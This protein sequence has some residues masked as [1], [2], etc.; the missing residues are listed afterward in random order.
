M[1]QLL[2]LKVGDTVYLY[3]LVCLADKSEV[4]IHR[5]VNI[6]KVTPRFNLVTGE[7]ASGIKHVIKANEGTVYRN[8]LWLTE[9]D[10]PKAKLILIENY[11]RKIDI[12]KHDI[13]LLQDRI[14]L[15]SES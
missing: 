4:F 2:D 8:L 15:I 6:V 11:N 13:A 5:E 9:D 12:A 1:K 14:E 7:T 10:L 3:G